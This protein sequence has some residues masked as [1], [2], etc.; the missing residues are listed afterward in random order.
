MSN[1]VEGIVSHVFDG[2]EGDTQEAQD[3]LREILTNDWDL[4]GPIKELVESGGTTTQ[5]ID[6]I[7]LCETRISTK[8][9]LHRGDYS[10]R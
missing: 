4:L 6:A 3:R 1:A 5:F 7:D 2:V 9:A 8:Q 10:W